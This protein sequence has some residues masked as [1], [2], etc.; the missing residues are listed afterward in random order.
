MLKIDTLVLRAKRKIQ[1]SP[2]FLQLIALQGRFEVAGLQSAFSVL[3]DAPAAT[4]YGG[5]QNIIL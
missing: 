2:R 4:V 1:C 3:S 5:R